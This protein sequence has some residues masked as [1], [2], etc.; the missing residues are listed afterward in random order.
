MKT[1]QMSAIVCALLVIAGCSKNTK[2]PE[3]WTSMTSPG[4]TIIEVVNLGPNEKKSFSIQGVGQ[5]QLGILVREVDEM[6]SRSNKDENDQ[7]GMYLTQS[8][9]GKYIGTYY[10][11]STLFDLSNGVDF[12]VE[13]RSPIA[14]DILVYS[15]PTR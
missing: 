14:S 4:K 13:N 1:L 10:S 12:I 3:W 15:E 2:E 7:G 5:K 6:K 8:S 9:S 11:A